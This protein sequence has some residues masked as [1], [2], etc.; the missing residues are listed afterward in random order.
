MGMGFGLGVELKG[1]LAGVL[2]SV[3]GVFGF[4]LRFSRLKRAN[5]LQAAAFAKTGR[6]QNDVGLP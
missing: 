6:L 5:G 2:G 4:T 1:T 3:A